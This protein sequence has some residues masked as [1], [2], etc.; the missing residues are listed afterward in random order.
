MS[1]TRETAPANALRVNGFMT[2]TE[3]AQDDRTL[4]LHDV[5][6]IDGGSLLWFEEP[7]VLAVMHARSA[8]EVKRYEGTWEPRG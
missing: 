4:N 1:T 6:F 7:N 8:G 3:V 5:L 2:V